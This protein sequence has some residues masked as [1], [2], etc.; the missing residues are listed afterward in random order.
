MAELEITVPRPQRWDVPF[1]ERMSD[2]EVDLLLGVEPFRRADPTAFPP[3]LPAARSPAKRHSHRPFRQ[4][5][6]QSS[7]RET[8]GTARSWCSMAQFASR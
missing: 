4:R 3:A 8:T 2:A 1:G 6:P 5:R 7:A